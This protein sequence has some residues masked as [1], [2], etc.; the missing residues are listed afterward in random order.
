MPSQSVL[1]NKR[2]FTALLTCPQGPKCTQPLT[3]QLVNGCNLF[4]CQTTPT[5]GDKT[6]KGKQVCYMFQFTLSL[7]HEPFAFC[8]KQ[9]CDLLRFSTS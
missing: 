6:Q 1:L 2:N 3:S 5:S 4:F 7:M 8:T 9:N